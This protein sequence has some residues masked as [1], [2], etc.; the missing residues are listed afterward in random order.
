MVGFYEFGAY[1]AMTG[2]FLRVTPDL[3]GRHPEKIFM[4][5]SFSY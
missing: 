1:S 3:P 5:F 2:S 4:P